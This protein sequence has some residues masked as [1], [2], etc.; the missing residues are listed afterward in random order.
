MTYQ[1]AAYKTAIYGDNVEYPFMSLCEEA[2]EVIGKLGKFVRKNDV[3][4]GDAIHAAIGPH[5]PHEV[6]LRAD[7]IKEL[8]D[9]HWNLAACC[10]ELGITLEELQ[11][12]N[13]SKLGLRVE[14]GT[15]EGSG[16]DR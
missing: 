15:L 4:V 1:E 6:K 12:A 2:G 9:L 14:K 3:Y 8:G 16:D 10:T 13:L 11:D 5:M 7:L